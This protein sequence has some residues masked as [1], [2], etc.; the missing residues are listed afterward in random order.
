[1]KEKNKHILDQAIRQLPQYEP[2]AEI[3]NFIRED[4]DF[5]FENERLKEG[6]ERL[7]QYDPPDTLWDEIDR[8]LDAPAPTLRVVSKSRRLLPAFWR[9]IAAAV[10]ILLAVGL[11]NQTPQTQTDSAGELSYSTEVVDEQLIKKDWNDDER[12]FDELMAMCK[13][14]I[15][16]CASPDFQK[17][18]SE[19][20]ELTKAKKELDSALGRFGTDPVL[21]TQIKNLELERTELMKA[22]IEKL[23]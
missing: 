20:D 6:L 11:W 3:W 5:G 15:N 9:T 2:P 12:A 22:M 14:K 16:T 4:L 13:V 21:I 23:I 7:P 19:L 10:V 1:M 18:K 8:K 17:L